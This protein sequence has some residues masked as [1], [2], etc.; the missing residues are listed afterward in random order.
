MLDLEVPDLE[1]MRENAGNAGQKQKQDEH[2]KPETLLQGKW[3][4]R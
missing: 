2:G 4:Q 1:F 3:R